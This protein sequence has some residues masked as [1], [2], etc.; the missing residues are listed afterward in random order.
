MHTHQTLSA[1]NILSAPVVD[2]KFLGIL[3]V[4]DLVDYTLRRCEQEG[5]WQ[6][7]GA[8]RGSSATNGIFNA[9]V[10]KDT[11]KH[12]F[13]D[14]INNPE[15]K[16]ASF[17]PLFTCTPLTLLVHLFSMGLHRVP[18]MDE[19]GKIINIISQSNVISFL[20]TKTNKPLLDSSKAASKTLSDLGFHIRGVVSIQKSAT[21]REGLATLVHNRT[22]NKLH[23][24]PIVDENGF[25]C[26]NFSASDIARVGVDIFNH[27]HK[28]V[29]EFCKLPDIPHKNTLACLTP[30][31]TLCDVI[32]ITA[33]R[34]IHRVYI[35][36]SEENK[37]PIGVVSL[38]DVMK[39]IFSF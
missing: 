5:K 39:R 29:A 22:N 18:I 4:V 32:H 24:V 12:V 19:N 28:T 16:E 36:E 23:A 31:A 1:N 37:K 20:A 21:V 6:Q 15:F 10:S 27:L 34:H 2:G 3:D 14:M 11:V 38:T 8:M 13:G 35:V 17:K 25:L 7:E 9:I 30:S 33:D 26:G